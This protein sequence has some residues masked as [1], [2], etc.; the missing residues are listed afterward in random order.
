[1][2]YA[3]FGQHRRAIANNKPVTRIQPFAEPGT[4]VKRSPPTTIVQRIT[5]AG[6][7]SGSSISAR[8]RIAHIDNQM[9]TIPLAALVAVTVKLRYQRLTYFF[10]C[11]PE[12]ADR[13]PQE[14]RAEGHREQHLSRADL[15]CRP[16]LVLAPSSEA[17]SGRKRQEEYARDLQEKK[18]EDVAD[19]RQSSAKGTPAGPDNAVA[20]SLA[21]SYTADEPELPDGGNLRHNGILS[22]ES[23]VSRSQVTKPCALR[24]HPMECWSGSICNGFYEPRQIGPERSLDRGFCGESVEEIDAGTRRCD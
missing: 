21:G 6:P 19:M 24:G 9:Q 13:E 3:K 1:M 11:P 23:G 20:P 16:L 8:F 5:F 14:H 2:W 10:A 7:L 18:V 4:N 22:A 15:A 12:R 17:A